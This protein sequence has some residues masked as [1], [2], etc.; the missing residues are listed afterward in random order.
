MIRDGARLVET[1]GE[2]VEMLAPAAVALGHEL[3]SRLAAVGPSSGV[4]ID[5]ADQALLDALGHGPR[6][7]DELAAGTGRPV[8]EL[9]STLL[10]LEL[11][12]RVE[13]LPGNRYQRLPG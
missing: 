4:P 5:V 11:A 10:M 3:A 1:A 9:T 13:A 8:A 2:I 12:G 6:A 7:L